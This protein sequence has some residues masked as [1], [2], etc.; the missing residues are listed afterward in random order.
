[1][2]KALGIIETVKEEV[3]PEI[4]AAD[5]HELVKYHEAESMTLCAEMVFRAALFRTETRGVHMR[6]DYPDQDDANWLKWTVI[7]KDGDKMALSTEPVPLSR[8]KFKPEGY[9][10]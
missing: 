3:L 2:K 1:M 4:R 9:Q 5:P 6:E 7:Q 10:G 8:Y